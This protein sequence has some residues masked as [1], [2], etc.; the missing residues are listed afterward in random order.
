MILA[1]IAATF[2]QSLVLRLDNLKFGL[3]IPPPIANPIPLTNHPPPVLLV[4]DYGTHHSSS[5]V[6]TNQNII[7]IRV[8]IPPPIVTTDDWQ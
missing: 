3:V 1:S 7:Q 2:I 5:Q 6:G 8:T 4:F